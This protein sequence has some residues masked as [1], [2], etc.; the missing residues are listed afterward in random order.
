MV[1]ICKICDNST[2]D[3]NKIFQLCLSVP[4][5]ALNEEQYTRK[6]I[7]IVETSIADFQK[8]YIP[9][10]LVPWIATT[11]TSKAS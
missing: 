9:E 4:D 7:L 8:K 3:K 1:L 11:V 10:I 2:S 5:P 6:Y